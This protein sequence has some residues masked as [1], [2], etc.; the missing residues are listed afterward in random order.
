MATIRAA[1]AQPVLYRLTAW[2]QREGRTLER[3]EAVR[4]RLEDMFVD[5]TTGAASPPLAAV[6]DAQEAPRD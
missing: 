4:P 6:S 3:L 1:D 2:A 5:L